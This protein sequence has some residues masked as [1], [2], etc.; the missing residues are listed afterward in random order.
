VS[1]R[2]GG[3]VASVHELTSDVLGLLQGWLADD[4]LADSR[5]VV[6]TRGA[7]AAGDGEA[8]TD[9]AAAA[10]G[11]LVRSAQ[12]ENPGRFVLVDVDD[13]ESSLAT[14]SDVL[15]GVLASG[16]PQVAVREG[17][18]RVPRMARVAPG[19]D[20]GDA[21]GRVWDP[22]GTVLITG[23]TGGLGGL[24]AR[25]VVAERGVRRLLLT[26]RRGADAPGAVELQ[27]ELIA[28]GA[29]VEI[30]AC[31]MADR[32]QVAA[33]LAGVDA[34]HPLTAVVHTAGVLADGTIPSLTAEGLDAVLRPKVDA[35]WHLHELTRDLDLAGFV[36]FSS[37]AGV[38]GAPGQGNYAAANTFLDALAEHR[39][40]EGLAALSLA[41][42]AWSQAHGMTGTLSEIEMRRIN[43]TGMPPLS[44]EQGLAMFETA[45]A[46]D[47]PMVVAVPLN[48]SVLRALPEVP[49]LLRGLVRA[50]RRSAVATQMGGGVDVA[51]RLAGLEKAEQ[52]QLVLELV[53]AQ[54]A[55]V[56]GHTSA[57]AI[58]AGREFRELGFDSL[59]TVELRN[60]L[61]AATGLRLPATLVF[62]YPTP[63]ILAEHLLAEIAPGE[64]KATELSL[65]ADLNR[66]ETA[67][68]DTALDDL[69]RN[70]IVTRLRQLLA[71]VSESSTE[72]SE[73]AVA[74]MLES[75][76]TK[77]I[78]GF[79]ESELGRLKDL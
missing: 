13:R 71:K 9:L 78:L 26:S 14:L 43:R 24:F 61:N 49:H 66:F 11:G 35:A 44:A 18:L 54:A 56:L 77:D 6:V 79:I 45:A 76:S 63:A 75:A 65:L 70:G 50:G 53:R 12:S 72:T 48:L 38:V 27:A 34:D 57:D 29:E 47:R 25:H 5:L 3:V 42:G 10:V 36:V 4:R 37:M 19:S 40:T 59:T 2:A 46:S 30:V 64:S 41:W 21:A 23:G 60:R 67:L 32:E 31:D 17:E 62:D 69:A 28:H 51:E 39:R 15:S 7:V 22:E 58:Q 55:V 16:E 68:S 8:V 52:V 74:G 73:I 20:V 1:G 33:L